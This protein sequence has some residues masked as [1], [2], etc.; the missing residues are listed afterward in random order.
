MNM[1]EFQHNWEFDIRP[2]SSYKFDEMFCSEAVKMVHNGIGFEWKLGVKPGGVKMGG[3]EHR[4]RLGVFH[5]YWKGL[6]GKLEDVRVVE[7]LDTLEDWCRWRGADFKRLGRLH[8]Q[9][10]LVP[11]S[12]FEFSKTHA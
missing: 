10:R 2:F 5:I 7:G 1:I 4:N 8:V 12:L 11:F 6:L 9:V 3:F